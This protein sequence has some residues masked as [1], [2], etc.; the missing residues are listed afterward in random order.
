MK[1][2]RLS[3]KHDRDNFDCGVQALNHFLKTSARQAQAKGTS[4]TFV[5][6][7]EAD[8]HIIPIL[9]FFTLALCEVHHSDIP[10]AYRRRLP[11]RCG[12]VRLA[13][14]AVDKHHQKK[15]YAKFMIAAA[16]EKFLVIHEGAGA[17]GLFVDAK[18]QQVASFYEWFGFVRIEEDA[19]TLFLPLKSIKNTLR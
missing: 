7:D 18:D 16:L 9:G 12:A 2:E 5:L 1:L 14:L 15:G 17:I 10:A 4:S 6:V 19:L 13:R 8:D 3:K 11:Q